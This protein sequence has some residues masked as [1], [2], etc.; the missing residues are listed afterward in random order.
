MSYLITSLSFQIFELSC[1]VR[2]STPLEEVR[3]REREREREGERVGT[4]KVDNLHLVP[5]S[6]QVLV[7]FLVFSVIAVRMVH[8]KG[9]N[10]NAVTFQIW[11]PSQ[12]GRGG[13]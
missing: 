12:V 1:Q 8:V 4:R 2:Y 7:A 10:I 9:L 6:G 5:Q 13:G 11:P 3:E